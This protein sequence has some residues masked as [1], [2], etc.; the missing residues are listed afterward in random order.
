M[1]DFGFAAES[2]R[3]GSGGVGRHNSVESDEAPRV[4]RARSSSSLPRDG[5]P[6]AEAF[7]GRRDSGGSNSIAFDAAVAAGRSSGSR[8]GSGL[9]DGGGRRP[10]GMGAAL[11]VFPSSLEEQGAYGG[12]GVGEEAAMAAAASAGAEV[13]GAG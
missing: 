12:R 8:D 9:A 5:Q 11:P 3:L 7:F 6:G 13:R 4:E 1:G 2:S 10:S